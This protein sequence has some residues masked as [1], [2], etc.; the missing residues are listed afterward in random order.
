MPADVER[1]V[2]ERL[3]IAARRNELIDRITIAGHGEPTLHPAFDDIAERLC[4]VRDTAA[5]R[6]R[7]SVL[8][9]STTAAWPE[10][11][12]GL[13]RFDERYMKLDAGD[14]FT[15]AQIN[16]PGTSLTDIVDAL[17]H[18]PQIVVRAMFVDD[19]AGRA[20]NTADGAVCEWLA[21]L[22]RIQPEAVHIY[23]IDRTPALG[24]L[25]PVDS[26]RLKEIAGRV[27]AAGFRAEV[28][29]ARTTCSG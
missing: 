17:S 16:R 28:F 20:V 4:H 29:P 22:E 18:L 12:C 3:E 1:A 5:P 27:H 23:T 21:A 8:S 6:V 2:A 19:T 15:Y 7:L 24:S 13:R 10:V 26:H 11:R 25:R 9:N 14:P